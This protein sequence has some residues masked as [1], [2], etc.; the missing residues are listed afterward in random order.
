MSVEERLAHWSIPDFIEYVAKVSEGFAHQAGIGGM[1]TA[2][3]IMSYLAEYPEQIEPFMNGGVFE[4]PMDWFEHGRLTWHGRDGK[5]HHPVEARR[6][7]IIN[8]MK[9][10][11]KV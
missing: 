7:R 3:N 1:E 11:Q 5:I 9:K 6:Q 4:F 8:R 10:G 2:G